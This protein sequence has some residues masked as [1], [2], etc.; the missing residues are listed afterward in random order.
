MQKSSGIN[1]LAVL[2]A[3]IVFY[4]VGFVFYGLV[5]SELWMS[6]SGLTE[7]DF[8]GTNQALNMGL[9]FGNALV[10]TLI[11]S[12]VLKALPGQGLVNRIGWAALVWLGFAAT[13][14]AYGPIYSLSSPTIFHIDLAHL[15]V[16]YCLS[17]V[18]LSLMKAV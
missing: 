11:L 6:A 12:V 1:V 10:T 16:A 8:E 3:A 17:T 18:V 5:F 4:F 13:T 7:A 2:L 14:L 15:L 9:G